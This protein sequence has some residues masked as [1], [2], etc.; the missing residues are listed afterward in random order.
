MQIAGNEQP[1]AAVL[2]CASAF[3]SVGK[4]AKLNAKWHVSNFNF[5]L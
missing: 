3:L 4:T 2:Q 1:L 5:C